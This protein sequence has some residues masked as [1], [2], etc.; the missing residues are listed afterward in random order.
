[1][2]QLTKIT[3]FRQEHKGCVRLTAFRD[4]TK[5][6]GIV[7][8]FLRILAAHN[9]SRHLARARTTLRDF[10]EVKLGRKINGPFLL[11]EHG[12][13]HF[14]MHQFKCHTVDHY[15]SRFKEKFNTL[16]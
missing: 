3:G 14:L 4:K 13:P 7:V 15:I 16:L 11:N 2:T 6:I 5:R 10:L 12:D 8:R 1:M 9:F